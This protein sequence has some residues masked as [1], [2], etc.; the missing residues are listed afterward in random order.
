MPPT[1]PAY[2]RYLAPRLREALADTPVVLIQGPRQSGKTTLA[3]SVGA[4]RRYHYVSTVAV[5]GVPG[6]RW[7]RRSPQ[8][9]AIHR[10]TLPTPPR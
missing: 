7:Y 1:G 6:V 8:Y 4:R 5:S 3:R 9:I 2:P 10:D